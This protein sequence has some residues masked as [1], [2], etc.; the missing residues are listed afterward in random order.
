MYLFED[1]LK[2]RKGKL[3]APKY[4]TFSK[5]LAAYDNSENVFDFEVNSSIG[6]YLTDGDEGEDAMPSMVAENSGMN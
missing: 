6:S 2:H 3:F 4:N 5:V 1:V